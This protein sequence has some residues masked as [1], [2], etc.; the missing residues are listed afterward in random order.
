MYQ[1]THQIFLTENA[2]Y[3]VL[4][5][6]NEPAH[7]CVEQA[8]FWLDS[9]IA[10]VP[11][12]AVVVLLGTHADLVTPA[13][14]DPRLDKVENIIRGMYSTELRFHKALAISPKTGLNMKK[15]LQR[16]HEAAMDAI[17]KVPS[18]VVTAKLKIQLT[19]EYKASDKPPI[20]DSKAL[21]KFQ[22]VEDNEYWDILIRGLAALGSVIRLK[23]TSEEREK[24]VLRPQWLTKV[25]ATIV[26]T[27]FSGVDS[28][29]EL[30]HNCLPTIWNLFPVALHEQMLALL[31][32]FEV[33]FPIDAAPSSS[34][35]IYEGRS[36]VPC[37]MPKHAPDEA[38]EVFVLSKHMSHWKRIFV[39][40]SNKSLPVGVMP[41][42][43]MRLFEQGEIVCRWR[44]GA[45]VKAEGV[46]MRMMRRRFFAS[47][48]ETE[49]ETLEVEM[50]GN[51]EATPVV[52]RL[53]RTI[54][55]AVENVLTNFYYLK[56]EVKVECGSETIALGKLRAHILQGEHE[57]KCSGGSYRIDRLAPGLRRRN[58][59][60][61]KKKR[62][63]RRKD[64]FNLLILFFF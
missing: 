42:L 52:A 35:S 32:D 9:I 44:N 53:Y 31:Q 5:R 47:E 45:V 18:A 49:K 34:S 11:K 2:L 27:K 30:A 1:Y 7:K 63:E 20:M 24:I 16:L 55:A 58:E 8:K 41:R 62:E 60:N 56:Y 48:V 43:L 64:S 14:I 13:D 3:L 21:Q 46:T 54:S 51:E 23:A 33:L 37:L 36:L 40:E 28:N 61:K 4:F 57:V 6:L 50:G 59:R 17:P 22:E 25:I 26:T 38:K 39:L 15:L 29:G 12:G 19:P 10:R